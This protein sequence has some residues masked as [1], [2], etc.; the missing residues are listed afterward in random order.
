M[1]NILVTGGASGLGK[2]IVK[3]FLRNGDNVIFTSHITKA[4]NDELDMIGSNYIEVK[5]DLS[6]EKDINNLVDIAYDEFGS[7]DVLINNASI[8]L[9]NSF[10]NKTKDDFI[11]TFEV[12]T[13][14]PFLL[15][16]LVGKRMYDSKKGVII[17]ISSNNSLDKYDPAT[18]D[19]DSSKAA[20]NIISHGLA[21]EYAPYVRVNTI[22]PGW[23][24][25]DRVKSLNESLNNKFEQ[26]ESNK[27]LLNRFSTMEDVTNL[28]LFLS[29][30]KS[31]YIND[32]IIR[33][34][35]G[36]K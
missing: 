1:S 20:L 5:T 21:K 7:I 32:E 22:A 6:S 30:D 15:S 13:I 3:A 17:N 25:T 33:I 11:K 36:N 4:S 26:E 23:I 9:E 8:E 28:V 29:S 35:G 12:N 27:I 18:I 16:R 34:D 31:S 19:Y 10:E 24:L 14:A 2:E